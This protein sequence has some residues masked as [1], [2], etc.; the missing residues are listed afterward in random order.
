MNA[1]VMQWSPASRHFLLLKFKY[2]PQHSVSSSDTLR[3][4]IS[5][6]RKKFQTHRLLEN[7]NITRATNF[8]LRYLFYRER[9]NRIL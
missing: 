6:T 4:L 8:H 1:P 9:K 3:L 5:A 7:Y 2:S